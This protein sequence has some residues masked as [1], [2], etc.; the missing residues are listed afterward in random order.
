VAGQAVNRVAT[1]GLVI[2]GWLL[3]PVAAWAVSFL[4][5][6]VGAVIGG[7][8]ASDTASLGSLGAG[9]LLGA[10]AGASAWVLAMRMITKWA[11]V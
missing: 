6:W 10:V 9:A 3:T 1:R 8:F 11:G 4:G 7:R 5:G 2:V